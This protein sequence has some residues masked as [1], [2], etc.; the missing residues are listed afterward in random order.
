MKSLFFMTLLFTLIS[1]KPEEVTPSSEPAGT[2]PS[3]ATEAKA[4]VPPG[5]VTLSV[6]A[7]QNLGIAFTAAE[8][9][10][11]AQTLRL[12]AHLVLRPEAQQVKSAPL[13]GQVRQLPS[14]FAKLTK[15][16]VVAS[17]P[18]PAICC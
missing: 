18:R 1:C 14:L 9:R 16:D 11:V 15:G 7:R 5:E 6:S 3:E 12:P 2:T 17:L 8:K 10:P 13:S 4:S